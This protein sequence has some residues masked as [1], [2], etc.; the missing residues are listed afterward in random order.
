MYYDNSCQFFRLAGLVLE[1]IEAV[2]QHVKSM[3]I[4]SI[5]KM[6]AQ[7]YTPPNSTVLQMFDSKISDV[8]KLR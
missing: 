1:C 5:S 3:F 6:F 8:V 4:A 7:F 2:L